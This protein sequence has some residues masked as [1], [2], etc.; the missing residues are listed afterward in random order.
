MR[1]KKA[2]CLLLLFFVIHS[3]CSESYVFQKGDTLYSLARKY[4][5]S[6]QS[7]ISAN[8]IKDPT[9]IKIGT[10]ILI[11]GTGEGGNPGKKIYIVKKGDTFYRISRNNN[12]KLSDL[13]RMNNLSKNYILKVG[14]KLIVTYNFSETNTKRGSR[15]KWPHPGKRLSMPGKLKGIKIFG[16]V[17]DPVFSVSSGEVVL[18][19]PYRG[20]GKMVMVRARGNYILIYGGNER[21]SVKVGDWI[22][23]GTEIGKLGMNTLIGKPVV[24]FSVYKNNMPVDPS[25][26]PGN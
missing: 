17:G 22:K 8:N 10:K 16:K 15:G 25:L 13:L 23:P 5:V 24:I 2:P 9:K 26:A 14:D 1:K 7:I 20:Y 12:I 11:P 4:G 21:T 6:V 18:V 19:Q 3:L